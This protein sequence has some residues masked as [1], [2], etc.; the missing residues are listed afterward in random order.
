MISKQFTYTTIHPFSVGMPIVD[1]HLSHN[2]S[3]IFVP[4]LVDSGA[5]LN[6]LP[7]NHGLELGFIWDKQRLQ[8]PVGGLLK[9]AEAY[10]ILVK[11]TVGPF[12][13]IDLAFAWI[14]KSSNEIR[15]LLG[16]VDFF[17]KFRVIFEGHKK[18]FKIEHD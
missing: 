12:P 15:T 9:G 6:I 1:I 13:P 18:T 16:Q 10:A 7:Y 14:N 8:L 3:E 11:F 2:E 17:Q 4:A 5:A